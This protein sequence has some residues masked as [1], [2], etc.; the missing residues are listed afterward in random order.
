MSVLSWR[1]H[2][3]D[4][5]TVCF[6]AGQD[7]SYA[8][9]LS[10]NHAR[11]DPRQ[12]A[13]CALGVDEINMNPQTSV[14]ALRQW[15]R[16]F[17]LVLLAVFVLPASAEAH[18]R[19]FV[20][21]DVVCTQCHFTR[22]LTSGLVITGAL[23]FAAMAIVVQ[24]AIWTRRLCTRCA[25]LY[26]LP[27]GTEWR[28]IAFLAG[29]MLVAN[30]TMRVFLAP[31]LELPG[32]TAAYV[33]L[34][35]QFVLG[36]LLLSQFTFSISGVMIVLVSA[37]SAFLIPFST[38]LNYAFEFIGLGLALIFVGPL[39]SPVDRKFF[40]VLGLTPARFAHLPLP[41]IRI[42]VGITLAILAIDEKLLH[43]HLTVY[44]LQQHHF[45]FMP[46]LGFKSFTDV[47]FTLA[48]GV[49]ELT[50]GLLLIGGIATRLVAACLSVF[51]IATLLA[52]GPIELVGH[53]PLFGI[54]F[55]L[56][57]R[58]A[59]CYNLVPLPAAASVL[60]YPRLNSRTSMPANAA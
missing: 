34:I 7:T 17:I 27:Q 38:L 12:G 20:D 45:N 47:H 53:A 36:M 28:L 13:G 2:F 14:A 58:G 19:W 55:L 11:V 22:D 21:K 3:P 49:A 59:G 31:N 50:F 29:L 60:T 10:Q 40:S 25:G 35:A 44:F 56:I 37:I 9:D 8:E 23:L 26:D 33:G 24:R 48:A 18:V 4:V 52:L 42:A 41:I 5:G 1:R 43:P 6:D 51:F 32:P 57:S 16:T 46:L 30:S 54:A 15:L 39:L